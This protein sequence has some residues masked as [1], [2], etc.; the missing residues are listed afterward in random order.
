MCVVLASCVPW[1]FDALA[2]NKN[3]KFTLSWEHRKNQSNVS[4][5]HTQISN[6]KNKA[7]F[8]CYFQSWTYL[9]VY[10]IHCSHRYSHSTEKGAIV[11]KGKPLATGHKAGKLIVSYVFVTSGLHAEEGERIIFA[12]VLCFGVYL[13]FWKCIKLT[14]ANYVT[15]LKV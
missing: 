13:F 3:L 12:Y 8:L 1:Y 4:L 14:L 7:C 10:H 2:Y 6:N 11:S 9:S 5:P 15:H